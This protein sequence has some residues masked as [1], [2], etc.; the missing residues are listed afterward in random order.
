MR[1]E[2]SIKNIKNIIMGVVNN[3]SNRIYGKVL[4]NELRMTGVKESKESSYNISGTLNFA[5][6]M[7]ISGN[8]KH[9]DFGF[10]KLQ[11]HY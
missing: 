10:H 4:V 9:K 5:D 2:P 6:L 11:Q 8:Y 7:T 1:G 3:S